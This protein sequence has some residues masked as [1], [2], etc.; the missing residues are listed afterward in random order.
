LTA[1]QRDR[2]LPAALGQIAPVINVGNEKIGV[3]AETLGNVPDRHARSDRLGDMDNRPHRNIGDAEIVSS[4]DRC[5]TH[6]G[7]ALTRRPNAIPQ[8]VPPDSRQSG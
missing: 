1:H 3:F 7:G 6:D 8:S 2:S 4:P 5:G